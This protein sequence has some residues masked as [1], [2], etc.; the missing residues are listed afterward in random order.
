MCASDHFLLFYAFYSVVQ[1]QRMQ[2]IQ[3]LPPVIL[4]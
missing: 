3:K 2:Y 1:L 4:I